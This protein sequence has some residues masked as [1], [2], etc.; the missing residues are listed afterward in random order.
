[1]ARSWVASRATQPKAQGYGLFVEA[2]PRQHE[3][4]RADRG[5]RLAL[6]GEAAGGLRHRLE[7]GMFGENA[8]DL[9]AIGRDEAAAR[10]APGHCHE[11]RPAGT[12]APQ[13]R[14]PAVQHHGRSIARTLEIDRLEILLG[15]QP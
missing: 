3:A 1:M 4:P 13:R 12:A 6:A 14:H 9:V 7:E 8:A 11:S 2:G 5:D 15:V 10:L